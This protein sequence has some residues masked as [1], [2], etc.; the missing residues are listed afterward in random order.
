MSISAVLQNIGTQIFEWLPAAD[1]QSCTQVCKHWKQLA[2]ADVLWKPF[3]I[4]NLKNKA[5]TG[6]IRD[7]FV[8]HTI[9]SL[10]TML[11]F[12]EEK[13]ETLQSNQEVF[14]S[15]A[16]LFNPGCYANISCKMAPKNSRPGLIFPIS[17]GFARKLPIKGKDLITENY[18]FA[19]VDGFPNCITI[20]ATFKI[21][22]RIW[23]SFF[24][25]QILNRLSAI[26][27]DKANSQVL[28]LPAKRRKISVN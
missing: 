7:L 24:S 16:F 8:N 21:S 10:S 6:S 22:K 3:L 9:F 27:R 11:N 15:Y 19:F 5:H 14:V 25:D 12:F 1:L 18:R 28:P 23:D 13:V 2:S 26:A 4:D 20:E 17:A